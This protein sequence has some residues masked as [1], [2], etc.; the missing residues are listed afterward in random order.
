MRQV[1][2]KQKNQASADLDKPKEDKA[3][4]HKKKSP[5]T[6]N[7]LALP[8]IP[9]GED[10]SFERHNRILR[11]EWSKTNRDAMLV[12]ELM[13]R[14]FAMWRREIVENPCDVQSLFKKFPFLQQSDQVITQHPGYYM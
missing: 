2:K 10:V 3:V 13:N 1:R 6:H 4:K 11:T 7:P 9:A 5:G 8:D 12:E 14:T